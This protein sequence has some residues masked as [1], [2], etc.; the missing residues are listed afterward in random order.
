MWSA[1]F[2]HVV[3]DSEKVP[4]NT[5]IRCAPVLAAVESV[6]V[7]TRNDAATIWASAGSEDRSKRR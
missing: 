7:L 4:V 5:L 3:E 2:V 1:G 6:E